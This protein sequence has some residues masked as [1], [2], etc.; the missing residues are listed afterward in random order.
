MTKLFDSMADLN[1]EKDGDGNDTKTALSMFSKD[2]EEVQLTSKCDCTGQVEVWLNRLLD[3]MKETIL[4]E[5]EDAVVA[6]E[7]K[8]RDQWLFDF[9]AQVALNGSQIWWSTEV[10]ISFSRLE[11]GFENAL[12]EYNKKQVNVLD[13]QLLKNHILVIL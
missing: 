4:H 10:N 13:I 2:H 8:P 11:E 7:E 6:Y 5:L 9:P 1:F 12:K 3:A